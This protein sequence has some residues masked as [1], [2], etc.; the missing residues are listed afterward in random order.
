MGRRMS[1]WP[2]DQEERKKASLEGHSRLSKL[3][4]EDR[5]SFE[6]ERRRLIQE[7]IQSARDEEQRERLRA[8]QA[9]WDKRMRGAGSAHNRFVLAQTFFG[10]HFHNSWLPG[11]QEFNSALN[12]WLRG[13]Q[14]FDSVL[15]SEKK[16]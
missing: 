10:Q 5:V 3:F 9:S 13:I 16:I 11:I 4:K 1:H 6:R 8:F 14:K 15:R 2:E 7:V 12:A